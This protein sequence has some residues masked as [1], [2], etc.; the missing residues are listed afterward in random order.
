MATD[1]PL[2]QIGICPNCPSDAEQRLLVTPIDEWSGPIVEHGQ[3]EAHEF[4][5]TLSLF[6][7]E[8]CRGTL[9]YASYPEL[10]WPLPVGEESDP[11]WIVKI[12]PAQFLEDSTLLWPIKRE[13]LPSSVPENIRKIYEGAIKVKASSPDSF[14]V[15]IRRAIQAICVDKGAKEYDEE[16]R[17]M[18]LVDML[19]QLKDERIFSEQVTDVFNQF[20]YAGNLGAHS[21]DETIKPT[22]IE[23]YDEIFRLLIQY[24]YEIPHKLDSLKQET[25]TLKLKAG[26]N[27]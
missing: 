1:E 13:T 18:K 8:R 15:Q 14:S 7:C 19:R 4:N 25:Q 26:G 22:I 10:P 24:I 20:R 21:G 6:T 3:I 16:G 23:V 2:Y 27:S 12:T 17:P 9:F 11:Y 5:E